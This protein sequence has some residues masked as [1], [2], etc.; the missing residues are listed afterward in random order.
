MKLEKI[1][2]LVKVAEEKTV[3]SILGELKEY[4]ND[5]DMDIIKKSVRAIGQIIL[6]V[7]KAAKK[8]VDILHEIV[9]NGGQYGL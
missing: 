3:E 9:N 8:A 6:K 4:S 1:D 5:M 2:V 7:D